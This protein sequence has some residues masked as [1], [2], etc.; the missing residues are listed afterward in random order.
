MDL[1]LSEE[2]LD[3]DITN[4]HLIIYLQIHIM[5]NNDVIWFVSI[6]LN[7]HKGEAGGRK[8]PYDHPVVVSLPMTTL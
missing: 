2:I 7:I 8:F 3:E 4:P 1:G 6:P 5:D